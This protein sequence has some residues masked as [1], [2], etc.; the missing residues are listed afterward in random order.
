MKK[1]FSLFLALGLLLSFAGCAKEAAPQ[2]G[3]DGTPEEI[4]AKIYENHQALKLNVMSTELDLSD[5]D[6]VAYCTGLESGDKL[7]AAWV[8]EPMMGSQAYSL[9]VARVKDVADAP[10]VAKEMYDKVNTAKWICVDADTKTAAYSGDVVM[11]FMVGS[12]FAES[13]TTDTMLE[14]FKTVCGGS[15]TVVG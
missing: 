15:V 6:A 8:S 2:G 1:L 11:F 5:A 13:A 9:V 14:A 7:S 12:Q 3:V 10:E 4:I